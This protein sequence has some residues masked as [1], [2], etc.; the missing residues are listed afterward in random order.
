MTSLL[1]SGGLSPGEVEW[2]GPQQGGAAPHPLSQMN[3][4]PILKSYLFP[5]LSPEGM[6]KWAPKSS[7]LGEA[8]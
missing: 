3:C 4:P 2:S 8:N 1:R 6:A 5:R 7:P